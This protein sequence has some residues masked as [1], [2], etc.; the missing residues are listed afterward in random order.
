MY[1][2]SNSIAFNGW[3]PN[4]MLKD[5][6]KF[7]KSDVLDA[8]ANASNVDFIH[9]NMVE[10]KYLPSNYLYTNLAGK[11][12]DGRFVYGVNCVIL[13]K[14]ASSDNVSEKIFESAQRAVGDFYA[15]VAKLNLSQQV[16]AEASKPELLKPNIFKKFTQFL[17]KLRG[18]V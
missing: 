16:S 15:N 18:R 11:N 4:Q 7:N 2:Q 3:K 5:S 17:S 1:I 6:G 14:N 12:I 8:L 9:T 10:T 13:P